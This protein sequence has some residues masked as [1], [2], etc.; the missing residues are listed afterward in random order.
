MRYPGM[1]L[2]GVVLLCACS[3]APMTVDESLGSTHSA[4][5][6]ALLDAG[7]VEGLVELYTEDARIMPPNGET[8]TGHAAVREEFGGMIAAGLSGTLT[9]VESKAI[10]DIAFN[11]GTYELTSD[12]ETVDTGKFI[13]TWQRGDDGQWRISN[14]IWNS[15]L[16]A[17]PEP[18]PEMTYLLGTHKVGDADTWLAAWRGDDG[19]RKDFAA[20]GAPHVHVMQSEDDPNL[21]GLFIGMTDPEAFDAWLNSEAG[22]AAAAEDTVDMRTLTLMI[23]AD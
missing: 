22:A 21:T 11:V 4:R 16:P 2:S 6:V 23:E 14:D 15:D 8:K 18:G 19:R 3:P 9:S 7:D 13:E 12:G 1:F 10:G 20:N 5:W 17:A